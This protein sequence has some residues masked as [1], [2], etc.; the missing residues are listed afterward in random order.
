ML[1]VAASK[2]TNTGVIKTG[3]YKSPLLQVTVG[4]CSAK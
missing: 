1:A 4:R 3:N 2:N